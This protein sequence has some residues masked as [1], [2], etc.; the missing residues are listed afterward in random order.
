MIY[1][2]KLWNW[3]GVVFGKFVSTDWLPAKEEKEEQG[4]NG[5]QNGGY[6]LRTGLSNF[7]DN[8][9]DLKE[10]N[11]DNREQIYNR[12]KTIRA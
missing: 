4:G 2:K 9:W 7:T 5:L 8:I 3:G 6:N 1:K 12:S 11:L 10:N